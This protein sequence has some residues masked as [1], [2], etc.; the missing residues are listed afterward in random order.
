MNKRGPISGWGA[1]VSPELVYERIRHAGD[2]LLIDVRTPGEFMSL[3]IPGSYNVPL[4]TLH[5]H[6]EALRR[7][8]GSPL[9]LVC[10]SGQRAR[11]AETALREI[12]MGSLHVLDGGVVA[13]EAAELPL[14]RGPERW[15][16]ER[17]VR[18]VAGLLVL[19]GALGGLLVTPWLTLL[20]VFMGA[21][22][23]FSAVTGWC[24][25]AMLLGKLPYNRGASCDIDRVVD[26]LK[27]HRPTAGASA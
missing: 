19:V 21:G 1:V 2:V 22:L 15:P 3:H 5:E 18:L 16:L 14:V 11:R 6:R 26:A 23:T 4:D 24:G 25:L 12:G 9:V 10:R 20:A 27:E 8:V 7:H 17:Q 13:W